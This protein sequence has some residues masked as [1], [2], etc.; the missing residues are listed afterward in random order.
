[1][2]LKL[3]NDNNLKF[4]SR[5]DMLEIARGV[6]YGNKAEAL[7]INGSN[8]TRAKAI[9]LKRVSL[10]TLKKGGDKRDAQLAEIKLGQIFFTS[11]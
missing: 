4:R 1:M 6:V 10:L 9:C 8:I 7:I 2:A 3:I 5:S 11:A